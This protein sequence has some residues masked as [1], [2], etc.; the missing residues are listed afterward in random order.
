MKRFNIFFAFLFCFFVGMPASAFFSD[1]VKFVQVTDA[2]YS[3]GGMEHSQ[4]EVADSNAALVRTIE[5]INSIKD[6]DFVVFTGD[7]IDTANPEDLKTFL[8]IV[9]NLKRPYYIVIGNHEVF[10]SQNFDKEEYMR[11]VRKYGKGYNPRHA[12]YIFK[13]DGFTFF[14]VDGAKEIIPG[15]AGYFKKD[16]LK[17]LDKN[18]NK[19]RKAQLEN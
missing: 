10:R 6:L 18:L 14:V 4:K 17:W 7:N 3:S 1:D 9:N 16:T 12:N 2:H 5:D 13:R 19:H 15:P 11:V 8:S